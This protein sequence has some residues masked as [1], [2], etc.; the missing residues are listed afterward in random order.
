MSRMK[1]LLLPAYLLLCILIGGSGQAVWGNAFLQLIAL[2]I[3]GWAALA[4]DPPA[5]ASGGRRLLL[6]VGAVALLFV[7]QLVPMPPGLWTQLPGRSFVAEGLRLLGVPLPWL[8]ISLS[9]YDTLEA[10]LTLLPPLALLVGMM[11]LRCWNGSWMFAAIIAGTMISILLGILQVSGGE[12]N[13]WYFYER[14]NLGVAVGT[15]ANGNHYATILLASLPMLGALAAARWRSVKTKQERSLTLALAVAGGAVLATGILINRSSAMLL[16]GPP[17]AA[18][19]ALMVLRLPPRRSRQA[20]AGIGLLLFA[21]AAALVLVGRGLP[22]WGTDASVQTRA[23]YWAKSAQAAEDH[24]LSGTG[25]GTFQKVYRQYEDPAEVDRWYVNHAHNDY[26]ELAVEGGLAAIVLM[27]LFLWWWV[28][29]ASEAWRF[30]AGLEHKAAA[31]ASAAIL[32]HSTFDYPLRT[33]A[34]SAVFA[35]CLALLAGA[36]GLHGRA[37]EELERP[38]H[39]T[40]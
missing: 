2:A 37:H 24:L 11:R 3:L 29:R 40:L 35:V 26:L 30:S 23:E 6:I 38:R 20:L 32:L 7:I 13:S 28:A 21:G 25:I 12:D 8:P 33:A 18:A 5:I 34:I 1:E 36:R 15:F 16:L 17:V 4:D 9:P 10:A 19:T 39:A 31:V 14:T 27:I 22:S